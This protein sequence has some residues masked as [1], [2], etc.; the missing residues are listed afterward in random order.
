MAAATV[1]RRFTASAK[2]RARFRTYRHRVG[3][4]SLIL[5]RATERGRID[6]APATRA[7]L[8]AGLLRK[9][10]AAS[11]HGAEDMERLLREQIRWS[12]PIER[13]DED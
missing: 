13:G 3:R 7:T 4:L 11:V 2:P 9:R 5:A 1:N 8:L 12:L 6:R 10:A